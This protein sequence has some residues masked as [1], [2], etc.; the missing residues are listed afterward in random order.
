MFPHVYTGTHTHTHTHTHTQHPCTPHLGRGLAP[1]P[2]T[3]T[4]LGHAHVETFLQPAVLAAVPGHLVDDAVLVPV[5]RIH[6]VLLDAS[7]EEAL[8]TGEGDG[9]STPTA[10]AA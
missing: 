1:G 3:L 9:L 6:H 10:G 5:T 7:S 2:A 4:L 8:G